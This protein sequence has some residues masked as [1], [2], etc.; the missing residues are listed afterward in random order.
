MPHLGD[1][2][3]ESVVSDSIR[4]EVWNGGNWGVM[5]VSQ[6]SQF[7]VGFEHDRRGLGGFKEI[8]RGKVSTG[9]DEG[10]GLEPQGA[11]RSTEGG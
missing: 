8:A 10:Q 1:K 3:V 5:R 11:Q 2:S 9:I 6:G 4:C 7:S